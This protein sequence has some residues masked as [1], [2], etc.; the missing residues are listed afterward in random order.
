MTRKTTRC[1]CGPALFLC[2]WR[3]GRRFATNAATQRFRRLRMRRTTNGDSRLAMPENTAANVA[4][5]SELLLA[6]GAKEIRQQAVPGCFDSRVVFDQRKPEHIQIESHRGA[7]AFQVREGIVGE[8][9]LWL[10]AAVHAVAAPFRP[11][12]Q[13]VA[14]ARC[15]NRTDFFFAKLANAGAADL[16][17]P[18]W[19]V[20]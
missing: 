9:H 6:N 13:L 12:D 18:Q 2:I 20:H 8:Q 1:R 14:H 7:R 3:P 11:A 17:E 4:R 10:D 19:R 5:A 15:A 16:L